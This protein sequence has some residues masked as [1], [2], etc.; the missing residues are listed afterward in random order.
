MTAAKEL[1]V[2]DMCGCNENERYIYNY[3]PDGAECEDCRE[4]SLD[5]EMFGEDY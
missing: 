2:C 4:E 5:E 1:L 3:G